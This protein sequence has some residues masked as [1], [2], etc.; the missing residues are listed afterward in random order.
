MSI[1]LSNSSTP[2]EAAAAHGPLTETDTPEDALAASSPANTLVD[3]EQDLHSRN[4]SYE[5]ESRSLVVPLIATAPTDS[6]AEHQRQQNQH[7]PSKSSQSATLW[8]I[9][10]TLNNIGITLLNKA[11]FSKVD[12]QYPY[13]LSAVHMFWNA[14]G[15]HLIF[16]TVEHR[17]GTNKKQQSNNYD[18]QQPPPPKE[19]WIV[20]L[21]GN[22]HRQNL[23]R[24]GQRLIVAFSVIFS[25]NIAI[26]NV[27]LKHV[28]VNFNQVMRS[29]VAAI[30]IAMGFAIGKPTSLKRI[31]AIV[32]VVIGVAMACFGDLSYTPLGFFYTMLAVCLAALKVVSS[33]EMLTGSLQLHPFDLL[34]HMAPLALMQC[35]I[36]SVS[37]GEVSSILARWNTELSPIVDLYPFAV[38]MLSGVLSFTFNISSLQANKLTS[39]LTLCIAGNVKQVLMIAMA[40]VIFRV[41]ITPLNGAGIIVVLVSSA[42]YSYVS[43]MEKTASDKKKGLVSEET[44]EHALQQQQSLTNNTHNNN[45][46]TTTRPFASSANDEEM[47]QLI[48]QRGRSD[49]QRT[50]SRSR[51]VHRTKSS[52]ST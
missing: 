51:S 24:R 16:W 1:P 37:T 23:D 35:L 39:P 8:L 5:K 33:G 27:S 42:W 13:F 6:E 14:L 43:I 49:V 15:S 41:E 28:S 48:P 11:A 9:L 10:W 38:V 4:A 21:L 40:T 19:H 36:L 45:T 31:C 50:V 20:Q 18:T 25:L 2:S 52:P 34:G 17:D 46:N 7:P 22:F 32:P 26:G 12:F 30:T 47:V 44:T 3:I 29:L